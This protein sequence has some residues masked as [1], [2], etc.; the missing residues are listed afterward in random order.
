MFCTP[1]LNSC[2]AVTFSILA[3]AHFNSLGG[4]S[5]HFHAHA[6]AP[7]RALK[8]CELGPNKAHYDMV[9]LIT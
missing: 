9:V 2:T 1:A 6:H 4:N 7:T 3:L 5:K 8:L